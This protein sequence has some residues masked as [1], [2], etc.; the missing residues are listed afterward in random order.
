MNRYRYL[1]KNI[2]LLTL[3]S[4]STKLLSFFLVP[5]YT[6]ILSTTEYGTYD[7][8][9]T[10]I[11]VLLPIL[12]LNIQE[13][14]MRFSIDSKY[15]RKSIVTVATRFFILSNLIVILGLWVN[16]TFVFSVIAKQYAIFFFLM[17]LSQSLSGMITMYVRGIDKI[18]DLS[19]SSAIA[20][21][22][23]ICLNVSFLAF[24]HWGLVGY[25]MANIIGPMVQ[26]L[27]L[28]VKAHVLGNIHLERAYQS[29][30]NE[31]V[32]YSKPLIVNSIAWWVNNSSDRYI[33]VIFCGLAENGIY[34]V[35]SKIPSILNIFQTIFN[36][37]WTLSA[38]KDFDPEDKNGFFTNTYKAYN[39]MMVLL[40]SGIIVFNKLLASF[41]Y[42]EDFYVAW[43]YVPW[44]TIAIVFGAMS[45]YF[46]GLFV[47]AN[48]SRIFAKSTV[49]GA[50]TNVI[51][52]LILT[53]IMGALGAAI[54]TAV[55]Y[56]EVWIFRY[57]QSRRYI[58]IRVNIFRDLITY[59]LLVCQS[60]ILLIEMENSYLYVLEFGI[61]ILIVLLY[62]KDILLLLNKGRNSIKM[63]KGGSEL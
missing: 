38:V 30:K 63:K 61:F 49:Y 57:L 28:I 50:I 45:G 44:L 11:G 58:R 35:A 16:Y 6:N 27:Y 52:N 34:S 31:M 12:T 55:S 48:D 18:Y 25:F 36:Q 20:A 2:G 37:A 32:N 59:F 60:I 62:F 26:S 17:F 13:A 22:I 42:A 1:L 54:A 56:F 15:D 19:V 23:T 7:L 39:C 29:E 5:L 33:V 8:F 43:K 24:L 14:V 53:P 9:N 3:S 47:A 10:T 40:C 51:L 4:F 21:V 46:E 41:L